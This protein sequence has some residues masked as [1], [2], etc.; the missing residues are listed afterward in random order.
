MRTYPTRPWVGIGIVV[1][2]DDKILLIKRAKAPNMGQWSLPG[3]AQNIGET[4]F[5]GA[6]REVLEET[7]IATQDHRFLDVVDSIHKDTQGKIEFHY[8]LIEISCLYKHGT[9][10]AQDDASDARWVSKDQLAE[11]NLWHETQ[12]IIEKSYLSR[13]ASL[14]EA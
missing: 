11:Y 12:R 4:V 6:I 13:K 9:L 2:K 8:T 3:G 7:G 5:E 14:T 10:C 1:H